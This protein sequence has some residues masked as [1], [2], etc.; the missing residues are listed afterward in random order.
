MTDNCN[1]TLTELQNEI[2]AIF[3]VF[4]EESLGDKV[5]RVEECIED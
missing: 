2:A 1:K 4:L 5:S 3:D